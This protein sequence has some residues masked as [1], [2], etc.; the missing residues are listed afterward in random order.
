M[1]PAQMRKEQKQKE[2]ERVGE[3]LRAE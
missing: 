1:S 3:I 2:K